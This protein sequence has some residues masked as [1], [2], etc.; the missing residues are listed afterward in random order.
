LLINCLFL[1]RDYKIRDEIN[2]IVTMK[3]AL[4]NLAWNIA[5][6]VLHS[7]RMPSTCKSIGILPHR[8]HLE[9]SSS[10]VRSNVYRFNLVSRRFPGESVQ[11]HKHFTFM[12]NCCERLRFVCATLS[13]PLM[14]NEVQRNNAARLVSQETAALSRLRMLLT[15]SADS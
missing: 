6:E 8:C 10:F 4:C 13:A 5:F 7:V 11:L 14:S 9:R 15:I 12:C 2:V 1:Q 3:L